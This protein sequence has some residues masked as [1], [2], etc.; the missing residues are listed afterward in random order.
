MWRHLDFHG[1]APNSWRWWSLCLDVGP[2]PSTRPLRNAG[3]RR[4]Q[5]WRLHHLASES[6]SPRHRA[7][8]GIVWRMMI[9][10]WRSEGERVVP[11]TSSAYLLRKFPLLRERENNRDWS[12]SNE[13]ASDNEK[14]VRCT[15]QSALLCMW[16]GW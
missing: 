15:F 6:A 14:T 9:G 13:T 1:G 2:N 12:V 11:T 8:I 16:R 4:A 5:S 7:P 3:P 10:R